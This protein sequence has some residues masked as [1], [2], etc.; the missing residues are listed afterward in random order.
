MDKIRKVFAYQ[1]HFEIFLKR[2]TQKVQDK[3]H[4]VI[5]AIETFERVPS[6]ILES[7]KR[8]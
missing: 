8:E 2:Q 7:Y 6:K 1:D 4:K 3:I 5:E